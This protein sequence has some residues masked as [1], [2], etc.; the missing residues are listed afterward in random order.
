MFIAAIVV[1][2]SLALTP[3]VAPPCNVPTAGL[4][5]QVHPP[6]NVRPWMPPAPPPSKVKQ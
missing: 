4:P 2:V 5:P 6:K 3:P 1:G